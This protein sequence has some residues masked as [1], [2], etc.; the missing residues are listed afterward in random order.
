MIFEYCY[1]HVESLCSNKRSLLFSLHSPKPGESFWSYYFSASHTQRP[2][3]CN[4]YSNTAVN[5]TN[6]P[7]LPIPALLGLAWTLV[8]ACQL[9]TDFCPS[10]L[11]SYNVPIL[12]ICLAS[13]YK[14]P[15]ADCLTWQSLCFIGT[16]RKCW[17]Q[18][19]HI[20][21]QPWSILGLYPP[22]LPPCSLT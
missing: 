16:H 5:I 1:P 13:N 6:N 7:E 17:G 10:L 12:H 21:A 19:V 11:P 9:F 22:T 8:F 2:N 3:W 14:I 15:S 18:A 20:P 4:L